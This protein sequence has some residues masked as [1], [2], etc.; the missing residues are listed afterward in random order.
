MLSGR[1]IAALVV[2]AVPCTANPSASQLAGAGTGSVVG[3]V[4]DA[5]GLQV[6]E[7]S[8]TISGPALMTPRKMTTRAD[9]EYRFLVSGLGAN[10]EVVAVGAEPIVV[11]VQHWD[12][13]L[14]GGLFAIGA[15]VVTSLVGVL[16]VAA[17]RTHNGETRR[18]A[19]FSETRE[20]AD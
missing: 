13:A 14:A 5:A 1:V 15:V 12:R 10:G 4:R 11:Q 20:G 7:V 9:G 8:I 17:R 18:D 2:I 16:M 19:M 6:P 3:L